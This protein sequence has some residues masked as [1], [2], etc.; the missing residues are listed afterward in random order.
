MNVLHARVPP[1]THGD[2][3]TCYRDLLGVKWLT[4][5]TVKIQFAGCR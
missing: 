4:G 2:Q 3:G 1:D 5:Y